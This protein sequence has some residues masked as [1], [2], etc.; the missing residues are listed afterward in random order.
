MTDPLPRRV[1]PIKV[2]PP[3]SLSA[4]ERAA[5]IQACD[6]AQDMPGALLPILHAVQE[7]IG[8]VPADAVALIAKQLNLSRAEVHG[9]VTFY[10]YFRT[11][12]GGRHVVH[13]CRAEACQALGA[14]ALERHAKRSL[15]IDF[16]A[17][18]AD[19]AITLEPVYCL[20]NCALGPSLM[21]DDEL[22]G[23][24]SAERFDEL[25]AALRAEVN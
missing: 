22:K 7:A 13:L 25:M 24:V 17:T 19:G 5:V 9:V 20:G 21:I 3:S 4:A 16:H 23:R 1:I 18:S 15:G 6:R 11:Q 2:E 10:H 8:F 14:Q 12:R